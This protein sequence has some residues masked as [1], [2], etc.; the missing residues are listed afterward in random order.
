MIRIDMNILAVLE[1]DGLRAD[2]ESVARLL[3]GGTSYLKDE[4][5]DIDLSEK[6]G[7]QRPEAVKDDINPSHG[8]N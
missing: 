7:R 1:V 3:Q 4:V 6:R 8:H 5:E 2:E